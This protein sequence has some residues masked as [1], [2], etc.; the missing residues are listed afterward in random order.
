VETAKGK[1][2]ALHRSILLMSCSAERRRAE[3][4][5][6]GVRETRSRVVEG[7]GEEGACEAISM[8]KMEELN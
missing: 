7:R 4:A 1:P 3:E 2:P 8:E 5:L 6:E